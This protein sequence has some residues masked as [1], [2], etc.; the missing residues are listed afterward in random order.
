MADFKWVVGLT[1]SIMEYLDQQLLTKNSRKIKFKYKSFQG[2][3]EVKLTLRLASKRGFLF[4]T[5]KLWIME[6][7]IV[8]ER[9]A[10]Y[11]ALGNTDLD[12]AYFFE[13]SSIWFED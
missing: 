3:S 12:N 13:L 11:F 7:N 6:K 9:D 5:A 2:E 1:I 4:D 10:E 8:K